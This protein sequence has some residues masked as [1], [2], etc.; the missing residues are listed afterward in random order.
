MKISPAGA[1][2][3]QYQEL[4]AK[5]DLANTIAA[6]EFATNE[7]ITENPNPNNKHKQTTNKNRL[8]TKFSDQYL[9]LL[10]TD[11]LEERMALFDKL[12]NEIALR[13]VEVK[14]NRTSERKPPRKKKFCDRRKRALR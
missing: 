1:L 2:L 12:V 3:Q 10:A 14:P 9:D 5:L 7:T 11:N 4:W 6:L 13:P 8:I